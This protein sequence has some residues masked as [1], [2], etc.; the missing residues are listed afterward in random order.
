M[1]KIVEQI[2]EIINEYNKIY[3]DINDVENRLQLLSNE[4]ESILKDLDYNRT[5][6]K[7]LLEVIK[8]DNTLNSK[9]PVEN[10]YELYKK[11][12]ELKINKNENI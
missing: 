6:E 5:K 2:L 7:E 12:V 4:R 11:I 10:I 1:E 9:F 8:N 3:D